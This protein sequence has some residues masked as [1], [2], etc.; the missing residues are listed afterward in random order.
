MMIEF[1][2][3]EKCCDNPEMKVLQWPGTLKTELIESGAIFYTLKGQP[4]KRTLGFFPSII[5]AWVVQKT[6]KG[7]VV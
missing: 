5:K 2:R 1:G 6:L 7:E 3:L 4:A